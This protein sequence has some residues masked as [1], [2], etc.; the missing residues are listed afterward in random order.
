M[1]K[2]LCELCNNE[3]SKE[4][5]YFNKFKLLKCCNCGVIYVYP[6]QVFNTTKDIYSEKYLKYLTSN[7]KDSE[8]FFDKIIEMIMEYKKAEKVLDIGFGAGHFLKRI[9]DFGFEA[10]GVE[11]SQC[12]C[13]YINKLYGFD[14]LFCG[15]FSDLRFTE[16]FD[17]VTFWDSLQYVSTPA[18]YIRKAYGILNPRGIIVIQVPNR[19]RLNF[20]FAKFLYR[21]NKELARVFLH[22]PAAITLFNEDSLRGVL[23]EQG[24]NVKYVLNDGRFRNFK[25]LRDF[26][27]KGIVI[28]II[29]NIYISL[30]KLLN[31]AHP[32]IMIAEKNS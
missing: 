18:Q 1:G 10:S 2:Y 19:G 20:I 22:L 31:E 12:A 15:D 17:I 8:A 7:S 29:D 11:I 25:P 21:I 24:F 4:I 9:A 32:L 30:A 14:K 16:K 27:L 23:E 5:L 6:K 28:G 13:D 26:S 3:N